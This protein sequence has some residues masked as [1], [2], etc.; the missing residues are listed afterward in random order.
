MPVWIRHCHMKKTIRSNLELQHIRDCSIASLSHP[1]LDVPPRSSTT[2]PRAKSSRP[3]IWYLHKPRTHL[4][5]CSQKP[6]RLSNPSALPASTKVWSIRLKKTHLIAKRRAFRSLASWLSVVNQLEIVIIS[7][8]SRMSLAA[9]E[10]WL[11]RRIERTQALAQRVNNSIER[12]SM[13]SKIQSSQ[14]KTSPWWAI[15]RRWPQLIIHL[16]NTA[17]L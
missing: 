2:A 4:I 8:V 11:S 6:S 7:T 17:G 9:R 12:L 3:R 5:T 13:S 10:T 15:C 1:I 14:V 16:T